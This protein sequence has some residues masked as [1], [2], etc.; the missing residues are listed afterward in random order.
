MK[1][2][3][4]VLSASIA[5]FCAVNSQGHPYASGVTNNNGTIT[6]HLNETVT[7]GQ[8]YV[9]FDSASVSNV[10]AGIP[11][12]GTNVAR[13]VYSFSLGTH[14]NYAINIFNIGTG[15]GTQISPNPATGSVATNFD[16]FAP[17]GV[18][19]N[20]NPKS[21]YFG[22]IYIPN[23]AAGSDAIRGAV[24]RGIYA[25]HADG[26]DRFGYGNTAMPPAGTGTDGVSIKW[27]GSTTFGP[28]RAFVG[29]DDMVYVSD[30]S[31]AGSAVGGGVWMLSP[32]L[33]TVKALFPYNG[34]T[35]ADG[36][37]VAALATIARGSYANGTLDLYTLEWDRSPYQNVWWYQFYV[38]GVT[39]ATP[40]T[41]PYDL[42]TNA[43][44]SQFAADGS[45]PD[46]YNLGQNNPNFTVNAGINS[47]NGVT[48]DFWMGPDNRFYATESRANFAQQN[49][50][51]YDNATNGACLLYDDVDS[52]PKDGNGIA[53]GPAAFWGAEGV[54]VSDDNQFL[55]IGTTAVPTNQVG[56][57]D[58][59][60]GSTSR[61]DILYTTFDS[62]SHLP[63]VPPTAITYHAGVNCV[64]R[65]VAFDSANNMYGVSGSDDS[66]R[67]FTI[68]QTTLTSYSNDTTG[69]NGNFTVVTPGNSVT[70]SATQ[71]LA[72]QNHGSPTPGVFTL[73]R[74]GSTSAL[75]QPLTV[76]FSLGGTAT[77][78]PWTSPVPFTA[79]S[80]TSV[81]FPANQTTA[82]VTINPL[83]DNVSRPTLTVVLTLQGSQVYSVT[84][85][86]SATVFIVNTGPQL[87][88]LANS[89]SP[90]M[91]RGLT[92]DYATATFS[93]WGDTNA[94]SYTV[95]AANF[96][97]AGTAIKNV[98]YTGL[99]QPLNTA[100][101]INGSQDVTVAPGA[102]TVT[103]MVGNPS[104]VPSYVGDKTVVLG[105][106]SGSG[107]TAATNTATMTIL[108]N[109]YQTE[110]VI[111]SN[112]LTSAT[113]S[114][115]WTVAFG[116][117]A[118]QTVVFPNYANYAAGT[119]P[120]DFDVEFGYNLST[121]SVQP[122][123]GGPATALKI[124]CNKNGS[125]KEAGVS[126]Y[127]QGINL[128]GDYAIRFSANMVHGTGN[129][130]EYAQFG[131]NHYGTNN[132]WWAGTAPSPF[133]NINIDGVWYSISAD[134]GGAAASSAVGDI[135]AMV[136]QPLPNTG[137]LT[138]RPPQTETTFA[139]AFKH[140]APYAGGGGA[141][142]PFS[143]SGG[144]TTAWTDVEIMQ[145]NG[146][147]TMSLNRTPIVTYTNR[148]G[149]NTGGGVYTNGVPMLG[150]CDPFRSVGTAA[151][152]YV[153]NI[154]A[155]SLAS[156]VTVAPRITNTQVTGGNVVITFTTTSGT[157]TTAN[158]FVQAEPAVVGAGNTWADVSPAAN[159]SGGSGTFQ[160]TVPVSGTAQFYRIRHN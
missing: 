82:T 42:N 67:A 104:T 148:V 135:M 7:N 22:T 160:A 28:Y 59:Y 10:P 76:N 96:T 6:F 108:D 147:V 140:P 13:G 55:L 126:V 91:Y 145:S 102:T 40:V 85:P 124:T 4:A 106:N 31:G 14:S 88:T 35:G 2:L 12:N 149:G 136:G 64:V 43:L 27:G 89:G 68:G 98:D 156:A 57:T 139:G 80:S 138:A 153:S 117:E 133:G 54:A 17:R 127:P 70:V 141:G 119:A 39:P 72:S 37:L 144:D 53:T 101:A 48:S 128:S 65:G 86:T 95:P 46:I 154:R 15:K 90:T 109:H 83:N 111:W 34:A 3:T 61:G 105:L 134:N 122:R 5:M 113:D 36:V 142:T 121:D 79:T 150:Y 146:I 93:R 18:G 129:T 97:Y 29:P 125:G 9:L 38:P 158:F 50:W 24:Q 143:Q 84:P 152:M 151:A 62:V 100:G 8:V 74:T 58:F 21:P 33:K 20:R 118:V 92:N 51:I 110:N 41:L 78:A 19:V 69:T 157:D 52:G 25:I 75:S 16:L 132:L 11:N 87:L 71:P 112:A 94:A 49:L 130:T 116:G 137:W 99:V 103:V 107:Y 23:G 155:V 114:T 26:T 73:T 60:T 131:I 159:I 56:Q 30:G 1:K 47:F 81:T 120:Q 77:Q 45:C 123:N 115:N 63:I 44:P 66:I 32:D